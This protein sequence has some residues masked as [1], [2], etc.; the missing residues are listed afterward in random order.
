MLTE[1]FKGFSKLNYNERL[2]ALKKA[3]VL[4]A[5]EITYLANGGLQN[6]DLGE[7]FI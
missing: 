3:G 5:D 4:N 2:Q 7:K 1:L 6:I